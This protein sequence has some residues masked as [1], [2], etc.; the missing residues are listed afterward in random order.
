M[1]S[2]DKQQ[3]RVFKLAFFTSLLSLF[4][5]GL[6]VIAQTYVRWTLNQNFTFLG[7]SEFEALTVSS[8]ALTLGL[9][10]LHRPRA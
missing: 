7:G 2:S 9:A 6:L 4:I 3:K 5:V 10:F 1:D 8:F